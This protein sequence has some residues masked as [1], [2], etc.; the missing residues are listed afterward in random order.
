M[1]KTVAI[2]AGTTSDFRR[3]INLSDQQNHKCE[4]YVP[5]K[6][7]IQFNFIYECIRPSPRQGK[8]NKYRP[9]E[10]SSDRTN[11]VMIGRK[12]TKARVA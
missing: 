3:T 5:A 9:G 1:K 7:L 12:G 11:N 4:K 10:Q 2:S 8:G 6:S